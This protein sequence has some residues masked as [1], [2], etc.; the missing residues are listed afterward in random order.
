MIIENS[1]KL[2]KIL[3][4]NRRSCKKDN[5]K[6]NAH[7]ATSI[8]T[9]THSDDC[10]QG[11]SHKFLFCKNRFLFFLL[12][13]FNTFNHFIDVI[14]VLNIFYPFDFI[15]DRIFINIWRPFKFR[16]HTD[17]NTEDHMIQKKTKRMLWLH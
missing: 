5:K 13:F 2:L 4:D 10:P 6:K 12:N 15:F 16:L 3:E 1:W 9:R 17:A 8:L 11:V 14:I 7:S